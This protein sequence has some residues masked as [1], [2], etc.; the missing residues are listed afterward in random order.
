MMVFFLAGALAFVGCAAFE[1]AGEAPDEAARSRHRM[2]GAA[3]IGLA[4][5]LAR[6]A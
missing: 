3:L 6:F 4:L 5:V 1:V 2:N